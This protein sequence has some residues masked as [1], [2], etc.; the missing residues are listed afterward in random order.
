VV[1][2][3]SGMLRF[4]SVFL[5]FS[6]PGHFRTLTPLVR[7]ALR[8]FLLVLSFQLQ[9][10]AGFVYQIEVVAVYA[11]LPDISRE[12][13]EKIMTAF[14]SRFTFV[15]FTSQT[16]FLVVV[17]AIST[18]LGLGGGG[19]GDVTTAQISQGINVAWILIF[20]YVGWKL[21]TWHP[22]AHELKEGQSL[23]TA[24]FKQNWNT[25]KAI[26]RQYK[27]GLRWFLL[28]VV[29]AEASA[30]AIT[31]VSVVYLNDTLQLSGTEVGIF[32]L[33][34]LLFTLPGTQVGAFVTRRTN[35]N[36]SWKL[37]MIFLLLILIIGALAL[38]ELDE[39]MKS[40]SYVWAAF[41]GVAL[42]WFYPTENLF[43]SMC[44]PKGQEAELAGFFVY[45]TQILGWLPPLLF[46]ILVEANVNQK[47]G[48]IVTSL[49]FLVATVIL[50]FTKPWP[51]IVKEVADIG[52][53]TSTEGDKDV[54]AA[55]VPVVG[56]DVA[57]P[58]G[59]GAAQESDRD[60]SEGATADRDPERA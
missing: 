55:T 58:I 23:W 20:F 25:A 7:S 30:A 17:I 51:D 28:A 22:P 2:D 18:G 4:L 50:S 44:L 53:E 45:C 49:G 16:L 14:S 46:S 59:V 47:Y 27:A 12:V 32:F 54:D 31:S 6:S 10:I 1:R 34:T 9:A 38:E 21:M 29:F 41:V 26:N 42:G 48:V 8:F 52:S 15:Q 36:T 13:G 43:F 39:G 33:V 37:S 57:V 35:P 3:G 11:Y 56:G 60:R 5:C 24:G 40:V 19:T